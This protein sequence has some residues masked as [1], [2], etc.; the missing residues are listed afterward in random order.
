MSYLQG[1]PTTTL[2]LNGDLTAIIIRSL[3]DMADPFPQ[4]HQVPLVPQ[5]NLVPLRELHVS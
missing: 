4:G 1:A 5:A 3:D 2:Q